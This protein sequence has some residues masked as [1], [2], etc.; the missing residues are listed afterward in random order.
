MKNKNARLGAE[1]VLGRGYSL[2]KVLSAFYRTR[3]VHIGIIGNYARL[4][5]RIF[6]EIFYLLAI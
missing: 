6:T 2:G 5:V 4:S 1:G 3:S